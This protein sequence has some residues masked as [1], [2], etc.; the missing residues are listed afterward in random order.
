M[1]QFLVIQIAM[2]FASF[3]RFS[4]GNAHVFRLFSFTHNDFYIIHIEVAISVLIEAGEQRT[5]R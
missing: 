2:P 1:A 3:A 4:D 5:I